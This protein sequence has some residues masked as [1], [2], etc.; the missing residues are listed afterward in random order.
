MNKEYFQ[1]LFGTNGHVYKFIGTFPD[2]IVD[3]TQK[4]RYV[5]IQFVTDVNNFQLATN[6]IFLPNYGNIIFVYGDVVYESE[7]FQYITDLTPVVVETPSE[8]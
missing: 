4:N 1:T 7:L 5:A 3:E 8:G 6:A 2:E